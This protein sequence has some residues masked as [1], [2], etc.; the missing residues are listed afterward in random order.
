MNQVRS[1]HF[2]RRF[3]TRWEQLGTAKWL[4]RLCPYPQGL[5]CPREVHQFVN[6]AVQVR[7]QLRVGGEDVVDEVGPQEHRSLMAGRRQGRSQ[8]A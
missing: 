6:E 1:S 4:A 5:G 7:L 3:A 8:H 2:A